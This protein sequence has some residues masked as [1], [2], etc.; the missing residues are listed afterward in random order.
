MDHETSVMGEFPEKEL[1]LQIVAANGRARQHLLDDFMRSKLKTF[2]SIALTLC[3]KN[4]MDITRHLDEATSIVAAECVAWMNELMVHPDRLDAIRSF[5]GKLWLRTRPVF[6]SYCDRADAGVN[7][8]GAVA[9]QRR[10]REMGKMREALRAQLDREP[11]NHEIVDATNDKMRRTRKDPDRQSMICSV[12]DLLSDPVA[13][14]LGDQDIASTDDDS[15]LAPHEGA[16]LVAE[17]IKVARAHSDTLGSIAKA[18]IGDLYN[19]AVQDIRTPV[20][21]AEILGLKPAAVSRQL[22]NL[23]VVARSYLADILAVTEDVYRGGDLEAPHSRDDGGC[24]P[25]IGE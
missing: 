5:D 7:A 16:R 12:N 14:S 25:A 2:R 22:A 21:V 20:Q 23:R 18:W 11:T 4:S 17:V 13:Y 3:R 8:S 19:P 9:L 15:L 10:M 24:A 6:R 1:I